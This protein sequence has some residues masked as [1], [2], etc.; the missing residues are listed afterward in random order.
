MKTIGFVDYYISEWHANNYPEWIKQ[1]SEKL[2]KSEEVNMF[3]KPAEEGAT[4][5]HFVL[6]DMSLDALL[7][8]FSKM[9]TKV[10]VRAKV[11]E[12]RQIVKD[13]FTVADKIV[14]IVDVV[15]IRKSVRFDELFDSDYSRS[16]I[17]NT[18]L[19]LLELLKLQKIAASQEGIF[20]SIN[21]SYKGEGIADEAGRIGQDY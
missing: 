8:A 9:L 7:D 14:H 11:N 10:E 17:I 18:F 15:K 16:E 21:I 12:P 2:K 5:T 20:G 13:R 3:F 6:K 19:A 1:A 4:D